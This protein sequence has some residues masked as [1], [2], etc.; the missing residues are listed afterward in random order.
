M[1]IISIENMTVVTGPPNIL[2][3][4]TSSEDIVTIVTS[5]TYT[6]VLR[7]TLLSSPLDWRF[8]TQTCRNA[9]SDSFIILPPRRLVLVAHI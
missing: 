3:S 9:S 2:N 4:R 1:I 7:H 6:I 8:V 5:A